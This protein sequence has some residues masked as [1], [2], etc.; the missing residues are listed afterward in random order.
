VSPI[1][2]WSLVVAGCGTVS[3]ASMRALARAGALGAFDTVG[4]IDPA[5]IRDVNAHTCPEYAGHRG[6]Y[7]VARLAELMREWCGELNVTLFAEDV[8]DVDWKGLVKRPEGKSDPARPVVVLIGL[9]DW[10][11]RMHVIEDLRHAAPGR[12]DVAPV[13]V[14]VERD[15]A[16]VT[17][18]GNRWLDACPACGLLELPASEPCTVFSS[19]GQLVRGDLQREAL[20][21]AELVAEIVVGLLAA[22]ESACS[23][24][25][26][27]TN[28]HAISPGSRQF[29][30]HMRR[31]MRVDGCLGPHSTATPMRPEDLF[32][33]EDYRHVCNV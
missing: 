10:Q 12:P 6:K 26:T 31:R 7:K 1:K 29:T 30:R 25:G 14:G 13:Q 11:S 5:V 28:L 32:R 16:Q 21:A 33:E 23:W 8:E 19:E 2:R 20:S 9:D 17:V 24:V 3:L 4:L 22:G 27:K 15:Q 18:F